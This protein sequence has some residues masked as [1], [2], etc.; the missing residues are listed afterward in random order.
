MQKFVFHYLCIATIGLFILNSAFIESFIALFCHS[1]AVVS[2]FIASFWTNNINLENSD[3]LRYQSGFAIQ[4]TSACSGLHS[5]WL[6]SSA[7]LLFPT[8]W[9]SRITGIIINLFVL[10]AFNIFRLLCLVYVGQ[11][12]PTWFIAVHEYLFPAIFHIFSL[13]IFA[14]WLMQQPIYHSHA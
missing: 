12:L 14:I 5:S 10:Q 1:L 9:Q 4:V 6:L 2:A 8:F 13:I 11:F 3:I 7:I